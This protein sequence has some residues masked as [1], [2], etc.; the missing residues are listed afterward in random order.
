[1]YHGVFGYD[2]LNDANAIFV[3]PHVTKCTHSQVIGLRLEGT[4]VIIIIIIVI[5]K[6]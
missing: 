2:R 1:M 3:T 5:F 4:L 6:P